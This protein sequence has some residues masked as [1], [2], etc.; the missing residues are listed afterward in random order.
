MTL[1]KYQPERTDFL[2]NTDWGI[3]ADELATDA[4]KSRGMK[5]FHKRWVTQEEKKQL[6][7]EQAAYQSIRIVGGLLIVI[8]LSIL[9]NIGEIYKEGINK[10]LVVVIYG[11]AMLTAGIGLIRFR[12][13]ARNLALL[14]FISFLVL[15]FT[16]L[17]SDDK[18]S[19]L[20]VILGIT[21]LYYLLRRIPRKIFVPSSGENV[22]GAKPKTSVVRR[23]VYVCLLLPAFLAIY[24]LYD[25][26]KAKFLAVDACNRAVKGMSLENFQ[27]TFSTNDYKII[28]SSEYVMIVP[29]RGM[30]RNSCTVFH[31][32]QKI[33]EAKTGF[34]D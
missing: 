12:L 13:F 5:L 22:C 4:A 14:V 6:R 15:P 28:K 9:I 33:T 1:K 32:G 31:D 29:Q 3:P 27:S 2:I 25:M 11:A 23:I 7:E 8:T 18:G 26:R 16:P 30:G 21:C 17:R 19:P 10:T 24:T 34:N 20:I